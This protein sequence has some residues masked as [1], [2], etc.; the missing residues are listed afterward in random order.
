MKI[1]FVL[2]DYFPFGGLERDC[3][4]IASLCAEQGHQVTL[5]T[6]TWQ[7]EQP[8]HL[9]VEL[10]GRHG[11]TIP[12]RNR[13]FAR[14]LVEILPQRELDG[15][16]G[17]NKLPGLD[18]YYG[19]DPCYAAALKKK[20]FWKRW[21]PRYRQYL[22]FERAVFQR[23][24]R[25]VI[26]QI[27]PR[28][29]PDYKKFYG[30]EDRFHVLPP[31]ARRHGFS[32]A[33]QPAARRRVREHNGWSAE[34]RV[35]LFVGSDF[36]RKGLDRLIRALAALEPAL[37]NRARLAVLGR[38]APGRFARLAARLGI[39]ARVHFLGG[40]HDVPDWMLAA[41]VMAHPARSENTGSVLVEALSFG[42]PEIVTEVCGYASHIAEARAGKV[43]AE[44]FEQ[45]SLDRALA[46]AFAPEVLA[47]WRANAWAYAAK[48][49]LFGCHERAAEIIIETLSRRRAEPRSTPQPA[50]FSLTTDGH[51]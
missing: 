51:G 13:H 17:F 44:P 33:D 37:R 26:L 27:I 30:T 1:G 47:S 22:A 7:G 24:A 18:V 38:D 19:A 21:L 20:P 28:D 42:L 5:F 14:R 12:A 36:Q 15:V 50:N 11:L 49:V 16:A 23:G 31:N 10:L 25:T 3:L 2:F 34:E 40:R 45:S 32:A 39:A 46:E 35:V 43:L 41:D 9:K 4:R 8:A 29:I 6:R 48:G